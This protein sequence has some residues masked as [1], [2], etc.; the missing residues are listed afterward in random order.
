MRAAH[1]DLRAGRATCSLTIAIANERAAQ[2][3]VEAIGI[4][5][6]LAPLAVVRIQK[7]GS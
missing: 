6:M 1:K 2:R 4:G 7:I 3:D 5:A